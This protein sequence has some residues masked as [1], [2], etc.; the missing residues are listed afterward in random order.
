MN[1]AETERDLVVRITAE[2]KEF[3]YADDGYVVFWPNGS[4]NGAFDAAN[5]RILADELDRRNEEWDKQV[6]EALSETS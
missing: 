1:P 2:R 3:I 5:L 4:T 6:R